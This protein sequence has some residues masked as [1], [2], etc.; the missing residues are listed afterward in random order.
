METKNATKNSLLDRF[1]NTVERVC[2]KLPPPAILFCILFVITAV[3]GAICTQAGF[4]LENPASHKIVTSQNFFTTAGIQWLLTTLVK[5]FTGFAPLGLV[6]TMTLAIGFCEE[7]GMLA[8]LLRRCM[9]GVPPSLVPFIVAFLGVC[10]NIASDT[11]MVVIPPLAAVAYIGVRK[12]PV[13]GMMVGF[14]GAEA[15]FGANLM[16]AGTDSLLQG[17]TN[18]AID[19]FFGKA[20]VFAVDVTCNWYFMF[21][22]T[23]L[24]AFIIALVSIKIVEPRFGVYDGPGADEE[25]GEVKPIEVKGL[26][27]AALVVV[28][29]ILVLVAGFFAGVLSKDGHTFV[30]SPLLKGLIPLLFVMFSLAGLTYGF[31]TGSFK[32]IKDVNKAMVHQMSGMGA[33][34]VFCFF[35]GQF[36]AL[37]SWT[38]LGTLLAIGGADFL[39]N[40]GFTG[41]P[42]C[43]LF[44]LITSL[45][46]IFMSSGSAKWA[47]FAP[48]FIPMFMLLGYHPGF[49][50][51]LYRLGDSPT[52]CF[53]PMNPYLWMI[54]SV[55]QEKYMPKAA[56]GTLV[57]NLIP[58]AVCLQIAWI[59]FLIGWMTLGLPIGPGVEMA[60]PAGVL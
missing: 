19:G 13:V 24:C 55:A 17:L 53:T 56:I 20:G 26:N 34:V 36:Q 54:L 1:L 12:H 18:Q 2:N 45:V 44:V 41:L 39:K 52:N 46:N 42:M 57:S 15:G 14:A 43:V 10:G 23:F 21:A 60:L 40:V 3:V 50:Q 33:F 16:I 9:K 28:A 7:S 22:S 11:A 32:T 38:H 25:L 48:I 49:T 27:R 8:A 58:I 47:I 35:C 31:T 4:A 6:I 37:F 29:Y 30:G 51:L 59:I 5:N